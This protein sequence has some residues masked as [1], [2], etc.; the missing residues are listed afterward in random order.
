MQRQESSSSSNSTS[1]N[2]YDRFI[3]AGFSGVA[4]ATVTNP[5]DVIRVEMFKPKSIGFLSTVV[6][7]QKST[8][9]LKFTLWWGFRGIGKNVIGVGVP[10]FITIF[11]TE[12]FE[13]IEYGQ[14]FS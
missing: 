8:A 6:K 7:L 12:T 11:L 1:S 5:F 10:V 13:E 9:K 3:K 2:T 14:T 4:G